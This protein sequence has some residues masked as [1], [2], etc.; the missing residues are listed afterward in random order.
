MTTT[1]G[2]TVTT[3]RER[4]L[5]KADRLRG[6]ADGR[7][8][9]AD[10]AH[11]ADDQL[12]ALIPFG[13]PILA[14]HHSQRRA[15]RDRDRMIAH[16]EQGF[17]HANK[18]ASMRSRADH[19]EA[20]ADRAIYSDDPDAVEKLTAKIA[21]LEAQREQVK[22]ANAA[23]RKEH[24][25]ELKTMTA[26]ERD[27]AQPYSGYVLTNLSGNISRQRKR[28]EQLQREQVSGPVDRI[29][30]ARF[31]GACADCGAALERGQAIRYTRAAGA[32]CVQ[33]PTEG[34]EA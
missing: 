1:E 16:A 14:G 10:Q 17:E 26:Y 30:T 25:A 32:R 27:Q 13:Q 31:A 21:A 4:R 19:I 15:E 23:Y 29:I 2:G 5:A 7:E 9:K 34:G 24:R 22:A 3:Y 18:A 12:R 28:L 8:I 6:W 20:A 33:C 11:H